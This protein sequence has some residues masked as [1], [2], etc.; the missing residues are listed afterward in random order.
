MHQRQ[1]SKRPRACMPVLYTPSWPFVFI[2]PR[3]RLADAPA[4]VFNRTTSSKPADDRSSNELLMRSS[5]TR[6]GV[7]T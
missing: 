7:Q 4:R 5:D 1:C 6:D 3:K 2:D